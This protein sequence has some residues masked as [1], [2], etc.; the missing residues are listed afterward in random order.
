V[1][2]KLSKKCAR[3]TPLLTPP[4]K[5]IIGLPGNRCKAPST[6]GICYTRSYCFNGASIERSVSFDYKKGI[7]SGYVKR[8]NFKH[9]LPKER[10]MQNFSLLREEFECNEILDFVN[11]NDIQETVAQRLKELQHKK[12]V[13]LFMCEAK[14]QLIYKL[15]YERIEKEIARIKALG[16]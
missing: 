9:M 8:N 16:A 15:T 4:K 11:K 7:F 2:G 3:D 6:E 12:T 10:T 1:L 5:R 13:L 14:P